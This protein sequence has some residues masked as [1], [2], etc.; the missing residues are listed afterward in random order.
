M[1]TD[2]C[3]FHFALRARREG[4]AH[5]ADFCYKKVDRQVTVSWCCIARAHC[6][7]RAGICDACVYIVCMARSGLWRFNWGGAVGLLLNE[8]VLRS[9]FTDGLSW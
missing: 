5:D 2:V 8:R 9:R 1:Y 6:R 7:L 3:V 4:E